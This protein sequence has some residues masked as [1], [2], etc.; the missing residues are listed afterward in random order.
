MNRKLDSTAVM[1]RRVEPKDSLDD[2][3]TPPWATRA[4][5]EFLDDAAW[6]EGTDVIREP[7]AN[8]GYMVR[9][10]AERFDTVYPSDIADYGAG[11]PVVD[12]LTSENEPIVD[13]TITNPP[14][15]LAKDFILKAL[16]HSRLGV[17]MILRIAFLE[18]KGRYEELFRPLP[19]SYVLQFVERVPMVKG[20]YDPSASSATAY[21]WFVWTKEAPEGLRL[22]RTPT[23]LHWIPPCKDELFRQGDDFLLDKRV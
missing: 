2:F 18:G 4:L 15:S 9:P 11:Y 8:R 12:Y 16:G 6:I 20:A 1:Q 21:A 13:W 14:F 17:A 3:P 23:E 22:G 7:A 10:L 19:P 5:L